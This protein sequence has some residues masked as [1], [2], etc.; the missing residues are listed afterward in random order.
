MT[1][2]ITH[3]TVKNVRGVTGSWP[4]G[5]CTMIIGDNFQG[6][7]ALLCA[8]RLAVFGF[9]P[10]PRRDKMVPPMDIAS[11]DSMSVAI[12]LS[13]GS[14]ISREW[15]RKNG[16]VTSTSNPAIDTL[17]PAILIDPKE[18]FDLSADKRMKYVFSSV[19]LPE[20]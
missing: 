2:H 5:P 12:Q 10:H 17:A 11:A 1:K 15:T 4:M 8:L 20:D 19:R 14:G 16:K 3:L 9:L 6:K 13:D 18:Y 7:S